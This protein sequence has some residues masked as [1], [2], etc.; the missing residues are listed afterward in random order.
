MLAAY[1]SKSQEALLPCSIVERGGVSHFVLN[2]IKPS[3]LKGHGKKSYPKSW[4]V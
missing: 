4:P 2:V 1:K 3:L